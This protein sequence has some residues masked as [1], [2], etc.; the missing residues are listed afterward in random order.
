MSAVEVVSA[1]ALEMEEDS[2][3]LLFLSLSQIGFWVKVEERGERMRPLWRLED[4]FP[5]GE[6]SGEVVTV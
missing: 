6:K 2:H 1:A 5:Q 4:I 3:P